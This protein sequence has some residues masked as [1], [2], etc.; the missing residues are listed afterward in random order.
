MPHRAFALMLAA[1]LAAAALTL[2]AAAV[3]G[4]LPLPPAAGLV[5]LLAAGLLLALRR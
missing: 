1:V 4:A 5:P 3:F 2:A